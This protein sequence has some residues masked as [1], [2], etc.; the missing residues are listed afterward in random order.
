MIGPVLAVV[1]IIC[2][3]I[4]I[5]LYKKWVPPPSRGAAG[6]AWPVLGA[7]S[8]QGGPAGAR[9]AGL[10]L[11]GAGERP[12][13]HLGFFLPSFLPVPA[14]SREQQTRQVRACPVLL[15]PDG[16]RGGLRPRAVPS[17]YLTVSFRPPRVPQQAEGLGTAHEVPTQQ[18][19]PG[20][21]PPQGPRGDETYQLP[22]PGYGPAPRVPH[23]RPRLAPAPCHASR[24]P[25]G[26]GRG[27]A[28]PTS[29]STRVPSSTRSRLQAGLGLFHSFPL[30]GQV[31]GWLRPPGHR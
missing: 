30:G 28:V 20:A 17:T 24:H 16:G 22:D 2:I 1:F 25:H 5:L 26:G 9:K 11:T 13:P 29:Q 31:W 3:V 27:A 14:D 18:C 6:A 4:A 19:R 8:P 7:P 23:A 15:P 10:E 12:P 21:P